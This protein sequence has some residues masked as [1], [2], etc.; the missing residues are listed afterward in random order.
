MAGSRV[1]AALAVVA[2]ED[3]R[4]PHHHGFRLQSRSTGAHRTASVVGAS[5]RARSSR[6]AKNLF[7]WPGQGLVPGVRAGITV[8]IELAWPKQRILE[9]YLNVGFGRGTYGVG[10]R[11]VAT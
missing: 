6:V 9:V 1:N 4:F 2:A 3:Q 5:G 7:L 11:A 10:P 8:L